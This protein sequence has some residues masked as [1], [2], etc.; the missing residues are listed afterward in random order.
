M[1]NTEKM[2]EKASK[3][4]L[5]FPYKGIIA[6]EDLWDL[7]ARDLDSIYRVIGKELKS[8]QEDSLLEKKT[9]GSLLELQIGIVKYVYAAKQEEAERRE[10]TLARREQ[11]RQLDDIIAQKENT[12]LSEKSLDDLK[13]MRDEME[14]AE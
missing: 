9:G 7:S 2:F 4:K 10:K 12:A 13:K 11:V 14:A 3:I 1:E 8:V 6:T 5:R